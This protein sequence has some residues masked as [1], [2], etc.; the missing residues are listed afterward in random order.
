MP[1]NEISVLGG[2]QFNDILVF[3]DVDIPGWGDWSVL[4][5]NLSIVTVGAST[6]VF[7]IENPSGDIVAVPI[8]QDFAA[9]AV[10]GRAGPS[11]LACP[12]ILPRADDGTIYTARVVS[13]GK[14]GDGIIMYSYGLGLLV[15]KPFESKLR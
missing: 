13:S 11:R 1:T 2:T 14:T 3:P 4:I 8:E 9:G 12:L 5:E 10:T 15:R 6:I 7:Q